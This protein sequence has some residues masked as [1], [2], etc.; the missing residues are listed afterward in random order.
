MLGFM[1]M[2]NFDLYCV[3]DVKSLAITNSNQVLSLIALLFMFALPNFCV[4]GAWLTL[5]KMAEKNNQSVVKE[6]LD[7]PGKLKIVASSIYLAFGSLTLFVGSK[8]YDWEL[9]SAIKIIIGFMMMTS[10]FYS[11]YLLFT[12]KPTCSLVQKHS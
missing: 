10:L 6:I 2:I 8:Y 11:A 3:Q 12:T 5:N 1:V 9:P 4:I 7:L